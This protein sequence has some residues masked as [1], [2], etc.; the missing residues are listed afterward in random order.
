MLTM[1]LYDIFYDRNVNRTL[2]IFTA[3]CVVWV[4]VCDFCVVVQEFWLYTT[5]LGQC[6][7][8]E[9]K[10]KKKK[11]SSL[12]MNNSKVLRIFLSPLNFGEILYGEESF[13][14]NQGKGY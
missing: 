10:I 7:T 13:A 9:I 11:Y 6:W 14:S 12:E 1:E 4:T 3:K 5:K 2:H 8:F